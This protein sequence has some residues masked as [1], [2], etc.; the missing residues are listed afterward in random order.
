MST[1]TKTTI[2]DYL[3]KMGLNN[4]YDEQKS[5]FR[6]LKKM[7]NA[8]TGKEYDYPIA[9][10]ILKDWVVIEAAVADIKQAPPNLSLEKIYD[11]MLRA[12]FIVPEVNYALY[13]SLVVS[14]AWSQIS[15]LTLENF[16]SEFIGV[17][18][19]VENFNMVVSY[20]H[21]FSAPPPKEFSP[22]YQ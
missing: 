12:N 10:T 16:T 11:G 6:M 20:A 22:I 5:Q 9:V 18:S 1:D 17:V 3:T 14:L 4:N 8:S 15:A 2:A 13:N 7:K 21:S 19:G